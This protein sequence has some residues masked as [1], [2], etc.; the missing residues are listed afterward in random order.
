MFDKNIILLPKF[1][2]YVF[3]S[4]CKM[5]LWKIHVK[6]MFEQKTCRIHV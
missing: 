3:K 6:Y 5:T 4:I 2:G 1:E